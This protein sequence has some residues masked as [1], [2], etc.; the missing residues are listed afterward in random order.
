MGAICYIDTKI[1]R[2]QQDMSYSLMLCS[3]FIIYFSIEFIVRNLSVHQHATKMVFHF[4]FTRFIIF[5]GN[6]KLIFNIRNTCLYFIID[7]LSNLKIYSKD[8]LILNYF[9]HISDFGHGCELLKKIRA[10]FC[11]MACSDIN[12]R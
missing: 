7:F 5:N 8:I 1:L 4:Y 12:N 2:Y 6:L 10:V 3:F 9:L 11:Q